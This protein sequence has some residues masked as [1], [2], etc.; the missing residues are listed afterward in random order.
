VVQAAVLWRCTSPFPAR[1]ADTSFMTETELLIAEVRQLHAAHTPVHIR[2]DRRPVRCCTAVAVIAKALARACEAEQVR[3]RS[4]TGRQ[5]S[6][7]C[8]IG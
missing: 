2:P 5:D 4:V 6:R 3:W 1:A 8:P 7:R